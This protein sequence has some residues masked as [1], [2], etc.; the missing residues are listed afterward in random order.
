MA[1]SLPF[2][3]YVISDRAR[4]GPDPAAAVLALARAGL[5]ALQW[6]EKDLSP[7]ENWEMLGRLAGALASDPAPAG[8]GPSLFVND[9]TD[10]ALALRWNLHLTEA[11][12][13][14]RVI[15][16]LLPAGTLLGR[17]THSVAGALRAQ[18]EGADFVTF[19][20]VFDTPSKRAYGPPA[21]IGALAEAVRSVRLPV[22]ALGGVT[23]ASL[24]ACL[25][26]GAYG[27]A[28]IGA[29]WGAADPVAAMAGLLAR[30]PG[31]QLPGNT[32]T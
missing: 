29:V 13:P 5:P 23:G 25:G 27:I 9:R 3:L 12:L 26:A 11:S 8:R 2:R 21:G 10:L 14:T 31:V 17:S 22:F 4:M 7:A 32:G 1:M 19:G 18:E 30:L 28:V 24:D 15:R 16:P 6:R 20:P